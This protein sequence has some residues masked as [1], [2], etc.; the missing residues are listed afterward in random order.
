LVQG[1]N[2]YQFTGF[3]VKIFIDLY[4]NKMH[5]RAM[6]NI[7]FQN[8]ELPQKLFGYHNTH[9]EKIFRAFNITINSRGNAIPLSGD[10][11]GM[12]GAKTLIRQLYELLQKKSGLVEAKNIPTRISGI[13]FVYFTKEDV[14]RHP[15]C[16]K[17]H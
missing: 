2:R 14:V 1:L 13:E 16:F 17:H 4:T 11:K 9:L 7:E 6:R 3:L 10:K 15:L 5:P 8:I 12:D